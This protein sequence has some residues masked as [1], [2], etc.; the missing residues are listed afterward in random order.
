MANF[1]F[2]KKGTWKKI[3]AG[4]LAIVLGV[5][6]IAGISTL[7]GNKADDDGKI[8]VNPK[9]SIGGLDDQGKYEE[10]DATLYTK[11]A[12]ECQGLTVKP[13]FDSNVKYQ[14]FFY[15]E[16]GEF[17]SKTNV[18]ENSYTGSLPTFATHARL[19][20]TPIWDEDV[21][22]KDQV[23]KWYNKHKWEGQLEIKVN[24]EQEFVAPV[25]L[26]VLDSDWL[27]V[28][29]YENLAFSVARLGTK[30]G[31]VSVSEE[32]TGYATH[33]GYLLKVN[34]GETLTLKSNST[35]TDLNFTICEFT[36]ESLTINQSGE[37]CSTWYTDTLTLDDNTDYIFIQYKKASL[38][39]FTTA[40][41]SALT[42]CMS[43]N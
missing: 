43:I 16:L 19:E 26:K 33:S 31:A 35:F 14:I 15:D 1:R 12:F 28:E 36:G 11:D 27:V 7:I 18:M 25:Y 42:N 23:I 22:E 17:V 39:A 6:A 10:S 30:D 29:D 20:V 3:L 13:N 32:T 24:E 40:E 4:A 38:S 37:K 21:K 8:V 9:W 5:G 41:L 2:R 34:G